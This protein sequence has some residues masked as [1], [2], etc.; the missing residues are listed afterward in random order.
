[1]LG[2][3][4]P[5]GVVRVEIP[6]DEEAAIG[7]AD[8][9]RLEA[10]GRLVSHLLR[11]TTE[12]NPLAALLDATGRAAEQVGLTQEDIDQELAAWKAERA[13]RRG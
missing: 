5:M 12:H 11:P 9:N 7:L 2:T 8:P 6:I 3:E 4:E 10:V 1:M 13:A